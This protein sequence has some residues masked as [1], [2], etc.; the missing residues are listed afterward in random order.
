MVLLFLFLASTSRYWQFVLLTSPR[1][2]QKSL[3][4]KISADLISF[5]V[6][7]QHPWDIC[8]F[9]EGIKS[10][11]SPFRMLPMNFNLIKPTPW[12]FVTAPLSCIFL[13]HVPNDY[14]RCPVS[15]NIYNTGSQNKIGL[16]MLSAHFVF[17]IVW[18]DGFWSREGQNLEG[19]KVGY[20]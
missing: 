20:L 15:K 6:K 16:Y 3:L 19:R 12:D 1:I 10:Y 5:K 8:R 2:W 4:K 7:K 13:K 18:R 11:V 9:L 17:L 14:I